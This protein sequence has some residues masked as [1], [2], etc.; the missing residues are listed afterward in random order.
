MNCEGKS[1]Q[2][3]NLVLNLKNLLYLNLAACYLKLND[4]ES[5]EKIC[6]EA[7]ILNPENPKALFRK[8]KAIT[9]KK[10]KGDYFFNNIK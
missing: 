6:D 1:D 10:V 7:I 5:T 8:A 4:F 3:K 2:E 9:Q